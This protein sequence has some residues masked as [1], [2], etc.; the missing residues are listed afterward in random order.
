[1]LNPRLLEFRP[2][3][4]SI[5]AIDNQIRVALQ[6]VPCAGA[7]QDSYR[8]SDPCR[9]AHG[10]IVHRVAYHGHIKPLESDVLAEPDDH[11]GVRL[12]A[13]AGIAA[14]REIEQIE[15]AVIGQ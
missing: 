12:G 6:I 5:D 14:G 4:Q 10:E 13:I 1:M 8:K 9:A 11:A 7:A 15:Y 2:L 3:Q